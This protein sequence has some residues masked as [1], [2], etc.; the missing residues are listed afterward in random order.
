MVI[1][2]A[3]ALIMPVGM[4]CAG[5][6]TQKDVSTTTVAQQIQN[7]AD[8]LVNEIK[9]GMTIHLHHEVYKRHGPA[10]LTIMELDW[11]T[12]EETT[13]D[14]WLG[15]VNQEGVFLGFKSQLKDT[16]GNIV[17]ETNALGADKV[18][19]DL[20]TGKEVRSPWEPMSAAKFMDFTGNMA[21]MLQEKGWT[22][23]SRGRWDG[24]ETVIFERTNTMQP[25]LNDGTNPVDI[26]YTIDL[27]PVAILSYVEIR[28]DKPLLQKSQNWTIDAQGA[29]T[30]IS[31]DRWTLVET[32]NQVQ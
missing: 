12:P 9:P 25:R 23:S 30:L 26:P 14:I 21:A 16:K 18:H 27:N 7:S 10:D 29:K 5:T 6:P 13:G 22:L 11:A 31:Q 1:L 2:L 8:A 3:L 28:L 19:Q 4:S 20:R 32:L 15:P 24:N 17:Q